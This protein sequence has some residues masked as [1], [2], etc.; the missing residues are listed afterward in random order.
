MGLFRF[1]SPRR[2]SLIELLSLAFVL[3]I[4][5][6]FFHGPHPEYDRPAARSKKEAGQALPCSQLP[7]AG[8]VIVA[9]KTNTAELEERLPVHFDTTLQCYPNYL[10]FSDWKETFQGH[11]IRDALDSVDQTIKGSHPDFEL[12]RRLQKGGPDS[13]EDEE[14]WASEDTTRKEDKWMWLPMIQKTFAEQPDRKWYVFLES[15]TYLLWGNLLAWLNTLDPEKPHYIGARKESHTLSFA[16][17]GAGFVLS[18]AA[19]KAAVDVFEKKKPVWE[20]LTKES[21]SGDEVV[22]GMMEAVQ[23][24]LTPA[25]P[26]FQRHKPAEIDYT[27]HSDG[28]RLWCYP[29]IS[30]HGLVAAEI[31]ELWKFEQ[32]W[33]KDK[34]NTVIRHSDVFNSYIMPRLL[35]RSGR[36]DDWDN[37]SGNFSNGT[38]AESVDQCREMCVGRME[39]VQFAFSNGTCEFSPIPKMGIHRRG[40]RSRWMLA[41]AKD[42]A[43]K[44]EA[45][46]G[47]EMWLSVNGTIPSAP[48]LPTQTASDEWR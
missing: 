46:A 38:P 35:I 8:D 23:A 30:Y 4:L 44:M 22:A 36:V 16:L 15:D 29:S 9:L 6:Y 2:K 7:G 17:A 5:W 34:P 18:H 27:T 12:W 41:R 37:L 19:A 26:I 42:F 45:C 10:L 21:P 13:L 14:M 33:L 28:R 48:S 1:R 31:A 39:C 25:W 11:E 47:D 24:P 32:Q 40:V 20:G 3:G 43:D